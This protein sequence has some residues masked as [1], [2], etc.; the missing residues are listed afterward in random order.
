MESSSSPVAVQDEVTQII[1]AIK[2][3]VINHFK[4][5]IAGPSKYVLSVLN[6]KK[7]LYR[8]GKFWL[9]FRFYYLYAFLLILL[10]LM[11]AALAG[12]NTVEG[13]LV[14]GSIVSLI[15]SLSVVLS[16]VMI[17]P[18]RKHP[19]SLVL[20]RSLTS[21]MFSINIIANAVTNNNISPVLC[22]HYAVV[23]EMCLISGE[24]WLTT[25]A[26]DMVASLT[27]PFT[28]YKANIRKYTI[29]ITIFTSFLGLVFVSD[30]SCQG[31]FDSGICWMNVS[32][33][34][35]PCL[36]GYFLIWMIAMY[37]YQLWATTFSYMRLQQG[38][39]ATFEVRKKCAEETFLCL[40]IYFVYITI[41]VLMFTII[42]ANNNVSTGSTQSNFALFLLF[43]IANRGSVDG[44]VWFMLHNF[45]DISVA[46]TIATIEDGGYKAVND[47]SNDDCKQDESRNQED[48]DRHS[49][50][51]SKAMRRISINALKAVGDNV[52]DEFKHT[53]TEIAD[54]AIADVDESDMSPQVNM[55]LRK[56]IVDF[57]TKGVVAAVNM[58]GSRVCSSRLIDNVL[59]KTKLN[60]K[61]PAVIEGMSLNE[62]LL[63]EQ[64]QFK[65]FCPD[66]FRKLRVNEGFSDEKYLDILSH[67]GKERLSEGASGAFMFFCGG[68]EFIVK[69]IRGREARVLHTMLDEYAQYIED[70]PSSLLCRFLGSYSL[71]MYEQ[72][73]YFVVMLN[74]FNPKAVINERFDI[75]GSWVGRSAEP[76]R[77]AK[78]IVCRH[79]NTYYLPSAKEQCTVIVGVHEADVVFKDN[80]LRSK[81]ILQPSEAL[82]VREILKNDSD[83]LCK[84]GT[85]DYSLLVGVKK[86][87]FDI[88]INTVDD[89]ITVPEGEV[90]IGKN[91]MF[92]SKSLIGPSTY[93][94]GIVDF[95]QDWTPSKKLE[96]LFKIYISRKDPDGLSVMNPVD[97]C[98]R[99]QNK[100][101]QIFEVDDSIVQNNGQL[102]KSPSTASLISPSKQ[103]QQH[104]QDI[105]NNRDKI[106][107]QFNSTFNHNHAIRTPQ[108][109]E[110]EEEVDDDDDDEYDEEDII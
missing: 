69:T 25:I 58:H 78:K 90:E 35:S 77:A 4:V 87:K 2:D 83:L 88:N 86:T 59:D 12:W 61:D 53:F 100:M 104:H 85:L 50:K 14:L 95:L 82:S 37:I 48:V 34:F 41:M 74:C 94:L 40:S 31:E 106:N 26:A 84:Y 43:V 38:L 32:S 24:A 110:E 68:N 57:V 81:I 65:S 22:Q 66:T 96:R 9:Y 36:W 44:L 47:S 30:K 98:I 7:K 76:S 56:Q 102:M 80:D 75:K 45:E 11:I 63:E 99:F 70:N 105:T 62:F 72:T 21:F 51:M 52:K 13:H 89:T 67:P 42:S 108:V 49:N 54:L 27:N 23:T 55:A 33:P 8:F 60:K 97:Y 18:W 101:N 1:T 91:S 5:L 16:Y 73:F 15:G 92:Y 19:S 10:T 6:T 39:D 64:F 103:Q 17:T 107:S 109:E 79:C 29:F 46:S 20:Y 93:Y 3:S 71:Q 28:S